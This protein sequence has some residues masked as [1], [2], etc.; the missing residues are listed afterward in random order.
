MAY[1][2]HQELLT[3]NAH[4]QTV[5]GNLESETLCKVVLKYY[6][7]QSVAYFRHG[8]YL[9][10]AGGGGLSLECNLYLSMS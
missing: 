4:C 5:A 6:C 2:T 9:K 1:R 3:T 10:T 7:F 8:T